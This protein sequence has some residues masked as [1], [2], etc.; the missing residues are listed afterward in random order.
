MARGRFDN[1][2]ADAPSGF[3]EEKRKALERAQQQRAA[4]RDRDLEAQASPHNDPEA[5]IATWERL[6]A[7]NLPRS[8][9]HSLIGL[10]ASQTGL[11]IREVRDEQQR[12]AG[13]GSR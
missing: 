4:A 13:M 9:G 7:L 10:I 12:R 3:A 1:D 2:V 6:H 11:A 5:R 8:P